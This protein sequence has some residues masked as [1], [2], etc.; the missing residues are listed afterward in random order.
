VI[1]Q[2]LLCEQVLEIFGDPTKFT[3]DGSGMSAP[4]PDC[5]VVIYY[6]WKGGE[7]GEWKVSGIDSCP[8]SQ[9]NSA[10]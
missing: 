8:A 7:K 10:R 9:G 5:G 6:R 3:I 1:E 2:G 4:Y